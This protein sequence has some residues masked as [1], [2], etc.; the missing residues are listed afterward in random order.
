[1]NCLDVQE[2]IIDLVIGTLTDTDRAR[3]HDHI[4]DC[5]MCRNELHLIHDCLQACTLNE[6][7]TCE[8]HFQETYWEEFVFSVHDK[9]AHEKPAYTFPFRVVIPIAASALLI[10]AAGYFLLIR[11]KPEQ[12]VQD[13]TDTYYQYDPYDEIHEL[14]PEETE[15]FIELINER[16][17]P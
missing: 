11:P 17:G 4:K 13:G 8:C 12:T 10:A 16:Y 6:Q 14:S 3:L 7:E 15:E 1:M 5:P 2:K 9:I